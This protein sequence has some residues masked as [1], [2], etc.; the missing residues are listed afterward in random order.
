VE[1]GTFFK[2]L[3]AGFAGG[4][5]AFK[6]GPDP[7]KYTVGGRI[8]RCPHCTSDFFHAGK[9]LLNTRSRELMNLA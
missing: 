5:A 4:W 6:E 3:K 9:A 7:V 8:V 2:A 1:V